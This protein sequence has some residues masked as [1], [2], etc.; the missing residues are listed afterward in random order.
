MEIESLAL[1]RLGN[2][3]K[4]LPTRKLFPKDAVFEGQNLLLIAMTGYGQPEDR[5]C[6][7]EA[8]FDVHLV[9]PVQ[10][11]HLEELLAGKRVPDTRETLQPVRERG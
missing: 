1:R 3:V 7:R 9:K 11:D 5:R 6:A 2:F 8:G 10:L 4:R